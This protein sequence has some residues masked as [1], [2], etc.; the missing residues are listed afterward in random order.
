M[1]RA[2]CSHGEGVGAGE[3]DPVVSDPVVMGEDDSVGEPVPVAAVVLPDAVEGVP[4]AAPAFWSTL[5]I[6]FSSSF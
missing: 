2:R 4:P 5:L 1:P 6:R 3:D